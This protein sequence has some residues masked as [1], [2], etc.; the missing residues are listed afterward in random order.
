MSVCSLVQAFPL[1]AESADTTYTAN[2]G[3]TAGEIEAAEVKPYA[4]LSKI[5]IPSSYAGTTQ[6]VTVSQRRR[7]EVGKCIHFCL[8]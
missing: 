4:S 7:Q 3:Y 6:N 5:V 8:L 2:D 1:S